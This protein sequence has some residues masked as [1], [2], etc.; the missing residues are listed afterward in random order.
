MKIY[1]LFANIKKWIFTWCQKYKIDIFLFILLIIAISTI[2]IIQFD[3][4]SFKFKCYLCQETINKWNGIWL[5]FSYGYISGYIL[6]LLTVTL[7]HF[8]NYRNIKKG[9]YIKVGTIENTLNSILGCFAE[10]TGLSATDFDKENIKKIFSKK[11]WTD[12]DG[13]CKLF[14]IDKTCIQA[15]S[16]YNKYLLSEIDS[17]IN[18]YKEYLDVKLISKLEEIRKSQFIKNS[19]IFSAYLR[20]D[21]QSSSIKEGLGE[22]FSKIVDLYNE[23]KELV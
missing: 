7:P 4:T 8:L 13:E 21:I 20:Y 2:I 23:I 3:I 12:K 5:E 15:C 18:T 10:G 16:L 11:N 17:L 6:F 14:G 1:K 9:I 19:N 22:D